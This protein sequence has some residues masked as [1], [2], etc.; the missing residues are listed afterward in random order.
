MEHHHPSAEKACH[1]KTSKDAETGRAWQVP[2]RMGLLGIL[3][4]K[5]WLNLEKQRFYR[6]LMGFQGDQTWLIGKSLTNA[7]L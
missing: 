4:G 7:N 6:I 2:W 1:P 3:G 5:C